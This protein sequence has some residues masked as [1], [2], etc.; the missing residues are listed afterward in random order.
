[1][2]VC[3]INGLEPRV[4]LHVCLAVLRRSGAR[5]LPSPEW[6]ID[7]GVG[8]GAVDLQDACARLGE[9]PLLRMAP[10][11]VKHAAARPW[12]TPLR[13][14]IAWSKSRARWTTSTGP[15]V[16]SCTISESG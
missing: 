3:G 12:R 6:N 16:S 10:S 14:I 15:N 8:G 11:L 7:P 13:R 1:M 9:E 2:L 4:K 5:G